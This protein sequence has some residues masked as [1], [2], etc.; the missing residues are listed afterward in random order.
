MLSLGLPSLMGPQ[1]PFL[2]LF[3]FLSTSSVCV[4]VRGIGVGGLGTIGTSGAV[5]PTWGSSKESRSGNLVSIT[6]PSG[7][8]IA[9][10]S[11]LTRAT[12]RCGLSP[13][14]LDLFVR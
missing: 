1:P 4:G 9:F 10:W 3:C 5:V 11:S 6:I 7:T 13:S 12:A 8:L 2:S 14:S